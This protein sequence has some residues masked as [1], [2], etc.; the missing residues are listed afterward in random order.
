[1][2]IREQTIAKVDLVSHNFKSSSGLPQHSFKNGLTWWGSSTSAFFMPY[3]GTKH[4]Q[5]RKLQAL[6]AFSRQSTIFFNNSSEE[7][8]SSPMENKHLC[9]AKQP[10]HCSETDSGCLVKHCSF[11]TLGSLLA[12]LISNAHKLK[13]IVGSWMSKLN[14]ILHQVY[15]YTSHFVAE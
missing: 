3:L 4:K 10:W 9:N 12:V 14:I 13:N 1:M 8:T 5:S 6:K 11:T 7:G 2:K 15:M